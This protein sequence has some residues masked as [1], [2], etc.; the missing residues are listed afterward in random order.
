MDGKQAEVRGIIRDYV[1][2]RNIK[3]VTV[4]ELGQFITPSPGKS[5]YLQ[6]EE[7]WGDDPVHFTPKGYSLAAAGLESLIYEKRAD[8]KEDEPGG[9]QGAAKRPKQDLTKNRP[10]WVKGSIAEAVRKD[11]SQ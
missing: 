8:E 4:T 1:R 7:I 2:M 10:D 9:W 3:R 11:A 5:T 6:E